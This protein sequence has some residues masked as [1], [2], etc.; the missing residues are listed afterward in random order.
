MLMTHFHS[1]LRVRTAPAPH[2][3]SSRL[4]FTTPRVLSPH[5][6]A[7]P[8]HTTHFDFFPLC[9]LWLTFAL[10]ICYTVIMRDNTRTAHYDRQHS[11]CSLSETTLTLHQRQHS[12]CSLSETTLTLLIMR[13]NTRT[14]HYQRQHSHCSL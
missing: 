13:D 8:H 3:K 5:L 11:H 2:G 9:H 6:F 10:A 1:C 14:A 12:H 4:F 7:F